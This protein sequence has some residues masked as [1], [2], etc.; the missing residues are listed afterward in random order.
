MTDDASQEAVWRNGH[1]FVLRPELSSVDHDAAK[2][3]VTPRPYI[4]CSKCGTRADGADAVRACIGH[5]VR[6]PPSGSGLEF[7]VAFTPKGRK[8]IEERVWLDIDALGAYI[9]FIRAFPADSR[10]HGDWHW[11]N[12]DRPFPCETCPG[13][14]GEAARRREV[15]RRDAIDA[16]VAPS[17]LPAGPSPT[18]DPED[19]SSHLHPDREP[20][21]SDK[22]DRDPTRPPTHGE[23]AT[24]RAR[25][26]ASLH[27]YR[28]AL[29]DL[30]A[31][32]AAVERVAKVLADL[33]A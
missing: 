17:R 32:P 25:A 10:G 24:L 8:T 28:T 31:S 11:R 5:S 29:A 3:T 23:V 19:P 4:A 15:S 20:V 33:G 21:A 16:E 12:A 14:G 2:G 30:K 6:V 22:K 13:P 18:L 7:D 27:D 26:V 1:R 9:D